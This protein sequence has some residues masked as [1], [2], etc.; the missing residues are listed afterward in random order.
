MN[1]CL[2]GLKMKDE[3]L[4][5]KPGIEKRLLEF[6]AIG[7][8]GNP[9]LIFP[10]LCFCLLTPQSAA[11]RADKVIK[12]LVGSGILETAK[13]EEIA[14]IIKKHGVRFHN[15]KARR[16]EEARKH[17]LN[18]VLE[19]ARK[20]EREAREFLVKNVKGMGY[21]EAGHFLRNVGFGKEIAIL[22]RHI[23]KNMAK[24]GA[25]KEGEIP[26]HLSKKDYFALEGKFLEFCKEKGIPPA[27]MDIVL[28]ARETGEIFK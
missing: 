12:E 20:D 8:S 25:V 18:A 21:K 17:D 14:P 3:Y 6:E 15:T 13:A 23:L 28:W 1:F 19:I 2:A 16:I 10:E 11:K 27:H 26:K 4:K 22:D 9:K 24:E 5:L 7:K